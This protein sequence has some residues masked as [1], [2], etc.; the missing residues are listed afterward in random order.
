LEWLRDSELECG[1]ADGKVEKTVSKKD[2]R[3]GVRWVEWLAART[4]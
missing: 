4:D 1:W 3:R 2:V